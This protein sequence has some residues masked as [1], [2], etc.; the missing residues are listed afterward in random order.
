MADKIYG[1]IYK[2]TNLVNN[3]VYI[4][5]TTRNFNMRY[6]ASGKGIE[7]VYG[8]LRGCEKYGDSHNV[9]LLRSIR[10][11]GLNNFKVE[12]CIDIAYSQEE[13][14]EKE[15]YWINHY[16]ACDPNF[17]YNSRL[18]G[19]EGKIGKDYYLK[20]LKNNTICPIICLETG[21]MFMSRSEAMN[22]LNISNVR[23][24]DISK[25]NKY[26]SYKIKKE[27]EA[28]DR[29]TFIKL[30]ND[31]CRLKPILCVT[32]KKIYVTYLAVNK[33]LFKSCH[34]KEILACCNGEMDYI[35]R[36]ASKKSIRKIPYEFMYA[37]DYLIDSKFK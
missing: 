2:I 28:K 18:G 33:D 8:Y 13:L 22:K 37:I 24:V 6:S 11:Y 29:Y 17:G 20:K 31:N 1:V 10:R 3:K 19:I 5:Q 23:I 25:E 35:L 7:R 16:N 34:T 32:N 14:D 30:N 12:E 26:N 15:K 9:H 21:E 4:G 27:Y 36:K